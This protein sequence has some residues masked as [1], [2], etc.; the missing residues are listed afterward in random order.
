MR[1]LAYIALGGL[2]GLM[3]VQTVTNAQNFHDNSLCIST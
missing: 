1:V 3:L 2:G